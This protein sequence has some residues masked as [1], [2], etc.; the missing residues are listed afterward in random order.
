MPALG[1]IST[2]KRCVVEAYPY[3]PRI[4]SQPLALTAKHMLADKPELTFDQGGPGW[5][6]RPF[7]GCHLGRAWVATFQH[8]QRGSGATKSAPGWQPPAAA[9]GGAWPPGIASAA[10]APATPGGKRPQV[11]LTRQNLNVSSTP[12]GLAARSYFY[13]PR[14]WRLHGTRVSVTINTGSRYR[15]CKA[16]LATRNCSCSSCA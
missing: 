12:R 3:L 14:V 11:P 4:L 5:Q 8:K 15:Q 2:L 9:S 7:L 10:H 1:F 6:P 16:V 13:S